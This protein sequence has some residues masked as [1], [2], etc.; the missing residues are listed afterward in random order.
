MKL[1]P[2]AKSVWIAYIHYG[3]ENWDC[4]VSIDGNHRIMGPELNFR[5]FE[6]LKNPETVLPVERYNTI[7][8]S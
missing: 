4:H 1:I 6:T 8:C 3:I 2:T 7:V 5:I